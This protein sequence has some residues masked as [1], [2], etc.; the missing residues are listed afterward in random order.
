MLTVVL[1]VFNQLEN[2]RRCIDNLRR[3]SGPGLKILVIDNG[4][5][6]D[7]AC[8]L[9]QASDQYVRN[10]RNAGVITALNQ[11]WPLVDTPYV[12]YLHNDAMI[13]EPNWDRKIS[14]LLRTIPAVGVAGFGGGDGVESNGLRHNFISS[15]VNAEAHGKR[16]TTEYMPSVVIDGFSLIV[17]R[18]LLAQLGGMALGYRLHHFYD[19]DICLEAIYQGY[20][21]VTLNCKVEHRGGVTSAEPDY[22]HYLQNL[23]ITDQEIHRNNQAVFS[24]KWGGRTP[25]LVEGEFHYVDAHGPISRQR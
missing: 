17:S 3:N 14:R 4:S 7:T 5:G 9:E 10:E 23:S 13:L 20:N 8:F 25:V 24:A 19:L 12:A 18:G 2:T 6:P 21:V 16:L 11:A 22:V 1:L 15:L